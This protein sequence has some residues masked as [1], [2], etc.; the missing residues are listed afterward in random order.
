M[1]EDEHRVLV[2]PTARHK[3]VFWLYQ[4]VCSCGTRLA[5]PTSKARAAEDARR[6]EEQVG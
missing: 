5:N 2:L 3:G 6:H 4:A 1:A